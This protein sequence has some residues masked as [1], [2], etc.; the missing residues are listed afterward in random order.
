MKKLALL[1]FA[2]AFSASVFATVRCVT[3]FDNTVFVHQGAQVRF[4]YVE[5]ESWETVMNEMY[6]TMVEES[7]Y[8]AGSGAW[9]A[10]CLYWGNAYKAMNSLQMYSITHA[11]PR[12]LN[13]IS[14]WPNYD[15]M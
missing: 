12:A 10:F 11:N 7:F 5:I 13:E 8:P 6:G 4:A 9:M 15:L 1:I 3:G 14:F 2:L